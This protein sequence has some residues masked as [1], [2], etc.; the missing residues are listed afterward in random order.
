MTHNIGSLER[1]LRILAGVGLI[2]WATVFNGPVWAYIGV[3]PLLTGFIRWCPL[4]ALLG[5]GR[6]S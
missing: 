1:T 4:Y 6:A 5:K 2:C 3:V